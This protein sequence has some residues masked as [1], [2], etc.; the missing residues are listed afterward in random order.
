MKKLIIAVSLLTTLNACTSGSGSGGSTS[1]TPAST[2]SITYAG[3]TVTVSSST[4]GSVAS[5]IPTN[6]PGDV[7]GNL[8]TATPVYAG[9]R[10]GIVAL[11]SKI[12]FIMSGLKLDATTA[13][14]TYRCG[15]YTAAS[16]YGDLA[17][18]DMRLT[19]A[20]AGN[21]QYLSDATGKDTTSTVTVTV[22]SSTE[23]KG[24][25]NITLSSN[26]IYYPATGSF[27]YHH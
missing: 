22:A 4:T 7:Y 3:K 15:S 1:A 16:G 21:K 25:F 11:N 20:D 24:T 6:N 13:L 19:D 2:F 8:N 14:G 26:G 5:A 18:G 10:I 12:N 17:Y 27:D 9:Y 23:C